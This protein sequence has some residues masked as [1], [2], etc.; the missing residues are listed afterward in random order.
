MSARPKIAVVYEQ[1][2][3]TPAEI[4]V[5]FAD[6]G[7][8]LFAVPG[9][10]TAHLDR[11]RPLLEH[12][13]EV[14]ELTGEAEEDIRRLGARRPA[15]VL[16][17]SESQLRRTSVLASGL[18]LP[19]H[20]ST[21]VRLLTDKARQRARLREAGV[22]RVRSRGLRTADDLPE[23]LAE[24]GLPAVVKPVRSEGSRGTFLVRDADEATRLVPM[25]FAVA[26]ASADGE[27]VAVVEEY[28]RGRPSGE[29]GDY[30]S[31]ESMS[32]AHGVAHLAVTGKFPSF[33][34]SGKSGLLARHGRP[35]RAPRD[36]RPH[37]TRPGG[38]GRHHGA[39]AHGDQTH[40]GR[41]TRHRGQ[42][43]RRRH[44]E[45]VLRERGRTEPGTPCRIAGPG[46]TGGAAS[47]PPGRPGLLRVQ[48]AGTDRGVHLPRFP[49]RRRGPRSSRHRRV[50]ALCPPR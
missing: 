2:A 1:G 41:P 17:F 30:V 18:G 46:R 32:G 5:G 21:T 7:T 47:L 29:S 4:A 45:R 20:D 33:R 43:T 36:P 3:V 40:S 38:P 25:V 16:T 37:H 44:V 50:P 6:L 48:R 35:G 31:V 49:R 24:V 12:L 34:R 22:D 23:A 14:V 28:L 15:A 27:P 8:T 26:G 13:G 11:V 19:Y 10:G 9:T 39:D 42:R